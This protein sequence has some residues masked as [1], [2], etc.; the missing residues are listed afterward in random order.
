MPK[1]IKIL[2]I[3]PNL[4]QGGAEKVCC[5]LLLKLDQEKF[6][7]SLLLFK[8]NGAGE[9][10]KK[11][12]TARNIKI[13]SL[14][15]KH[16]IDVVNFW[17]LFKAIKKIKPDIIHTHLGGDIYGRLAGKLA[18]VPIIV[19][20]EHNL[21]NNERVSA[22][23][24]KK[25]SSRYANK[26]FAVSTAV[27][28]DATTRYQISPEKITVIYNG[29]DLNNF[30]FED[31][32]IEKTEIKEKNKPI[33][34]GALGR[35]TAQKGF[36]VLIK[37][38]AKTKNKNYII[39]IAGEGE[40]KTEL[41]NIISKLG[42]DGRVKLLGIVEAKNFLADIDIFVSPSLWEGLGL[43]VLEA[44]AMAKPIIASETGGIKEIINDKTGWLFP[45]GDSDEL[46][47]KIDYVI[48]NL[49]SEETKTKT[50]EIKKLIYNQFN[51]EDMV[52]AYEDWYQILSLD[53]LNM[54]GK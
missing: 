22:A 5:E 28:D 12:L 20:T 42:L 19:S 14:Q 4:I 48:D 46:A 6:L 1:K 25:I 54:K 31:S 13:F 38:A 40:L 3:L 26:I 35:L 15:K 18:A 36:E 16:L 29:V 34:I 52:E 41:G 53:S 32:K 27:R 51:L 44:G 30:K 33:I 9:E 24:L 39:K 23:W 37:A 50:G 21:N 43:V 45:A 2:H 49:Y 47:V 11:K 17:R 10:W 7:P 8:E